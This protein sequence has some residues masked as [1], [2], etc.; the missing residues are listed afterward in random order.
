MNCQVWYC[1]IHFC[2][3]S[4]F[5]SM[6]T[7]CKQC[8]NISPID[9]HTFSCSDKEGGHQS[10]TM[11]GCVSNGLRV[12]I[13]PPGWT[14]TYASCFVSSSSPGYTMFLHISQRRSC[15]RQGWTHTSPENESLFGRK[16]RFFTGSRYPHPQCQSCSNTKQRITAEGLTMSVQSTL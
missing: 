16:F 5:I 14:W 13:S 10:D 6:C 12:W 7:K 15:R 4:C 2:T 8:T 3:R 9:Q 11:R 1:L